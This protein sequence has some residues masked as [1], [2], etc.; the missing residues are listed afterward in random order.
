MKQYHLAISVIQQSFFMFTLRVL[1]LE[2][3]GL[4]LFLFDSNIE[5]KNDVLTT[6]TSGKLSF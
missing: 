4:E 6:C 5:G 3:R 2:H 1:G